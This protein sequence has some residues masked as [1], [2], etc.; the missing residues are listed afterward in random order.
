[1]T[2]PRA[3]S[4]TAIGQVVII[5]A[6]PTGLAAASHLLERGIDTIV[7]EAG[8]AAGNTIRE[9]SH[10]RLFSNWRSVVD[11]ASVRRLDSIG[12]SMPD[13][14]SYPTGGDIVNLYLEP[15][16]ATM[17]EQVWFNHRVTEISRDGLDKVVSGGREKVPFLIRVDTP[18]GPRELLAS[19]VIDASG[20]WG[21]P[22]PMGSS[23]LPARGE[24]E[25]TDHIQYG[26]PDVLG[27]HRERYVNQRVLVV[28]AGHSASGVLL[29][30]A[31]LRSDAPDTRPIWA[32]RR[33]DATKVYGGLADDELEQ[34][35]KLGEQ[36]QRQVE[37]GAVEMVA[38]FRVSDLKAGPDG[39]EVTGVGPDGT[40]THTIV[41]DKIVAATGQR[42]D[43][44]LARELRLDLDPWLE[45]P[46]LLAPLIDPNEH[47]C[48]TVPPHGVDELSHPEPDYYTVGI[49]SYG[50]APKVPAKKVPAKK[51]PAQKKTAA[52]SV[53]A[54]EE[55]KP[56]GPSKEPIAPKSKPK[57]PTS[58]KIGDK[59]VHPHHGAA[60]IA[61]KVK[62]VVLGEK[63]DY[64]VLQIATDQLTV[65]VPI[66]TIDET[67]RPVISKTAAGRVLKTFKEEPQEAG[68]NWSRWYKVLNEK[69]TSGDIY[70]VAEVVR[71]LT[72]AQQT[73]GISPALKRMLSRARLTL[74]SELSFALNVDDEDATK[75]LD[76]ALPKP[77]EEEE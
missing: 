25:L 36:L 75:R 73:K 58:F 32:V 65:F 1:M 72:F 13:P 18:T 27:R 55:T 3:T 42:P 56:K 33:D 51:A 61:K 9:W 74:T 68:S 19:H 37:S 10:V 50:R 59:V 22:N 46:R 40:S 5:G 15:L 66:D 14:G 7:L 48:G 24:A 77:P 31:D 21:T 76:R 39:I 70:Q 57:K 71:D 62:Q 41:V 67:I 60:V 2:T 30:L 8:G 49:K 38:G 28:G 53:E 45:A 26:M 63:R 35:G 34:R 29:D 69:M 17:T 4:K 11:G 47:S 12:W 43:L 6:G 52:P 64:F 20:T 54:V 16:A 23:G 44:T